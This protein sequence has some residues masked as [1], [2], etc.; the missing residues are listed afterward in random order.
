VS[1]MKHGATGVIQL[2]L[3]AIAQQMWLLQVWLL[4]LEWRAQ[5]SS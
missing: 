3:T 2:Q 4:L 1:R 5:P